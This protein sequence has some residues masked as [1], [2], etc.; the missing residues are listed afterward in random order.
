M[1]VNDNTQAPC[2]AEVYS[3]GTVVFM[4]H[5]IPSAE[6][7]D[8]VKKVAA[9]SGQRVD[10]HFC[11]GRAVVQALGDLNAVEAALVELMQEHDRLQAAAVKPLLEIP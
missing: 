6:M 9:R 7:E 3:K 8:W 4:T 1:S 11:G 5:S 2:D 10:W